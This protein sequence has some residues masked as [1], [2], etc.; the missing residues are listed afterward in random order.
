MWKYILLIFIVALFANSYL[1]NYWAILA[2]D[3]HRICLSLFPKNLSHSEIYQAYICGEIRQRPSP[4]FASLF[5]TTVDSLRPILS[6]SGLHILIIE[7]LM[8]ALSYRR[9]PFRALVVFALATVLS[10]MAL[11]PSVLVR[12]WLNLLVK[13]YCNEERLNWPISII[14]LTTGLLCAVLNP[15]W[16]QSFSFLICWLASLALQLPIRKILPRILMSAT[17]I[18]P[19]T[20]T[21]SHEALLSRLC[22]FFL[23]PTALALFWPASLLVAAYH[24]FAI[25]FAPLWQALGRLTADFQSIVGPTT[26][27]FEDSAIFSKTE[28]FGPLTY[29]LFVH[30]LTF[31]IERQLRKEK[32][33]PDCR[34]GAIRV[35]L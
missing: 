1:I 2:S 19:L 9:S 10:F 15:N 18:C 3:S 28:F 20:L 13:N 30:L 6:I 16:L 26:D 29:V 8:S 35:E 24:P 34:D 11:L 4:Q 17:L 27:N 5:T 32:Y 21:H 22:L 7:R 33:W 14:S 25:S 12:A 23:K 31:L